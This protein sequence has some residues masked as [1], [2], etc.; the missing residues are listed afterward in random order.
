MKSR[1]ARDDGPRSPQPNGPKRL[2]RWTR[3]PLAR[4]PSR[5][6]LTDSIEEGARGA[7]TVTV[8]S[9]GFEDDSERRDPARPELAP[10]LARLGRRGEE[11][12]EGRRR[13]LV[14]RR[15]AQREVLALG[16]EDRAPRDRDGVA[17]ERRVEGR[18]VDGRAR[19]R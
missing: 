8:S 17:G 18:D 13:P 9:G 4:S 1:N 19:R 3:R 16:A 11:P 2:V 12:R 7:S 6:M 15:R 5:G 10:E 14:E